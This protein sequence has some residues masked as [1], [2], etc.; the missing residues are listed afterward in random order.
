MQRLIVNVVIVPDTRIK[1]VF[2]TFSF[3]GLK[4]IIIN[5]T[6]TKNRERK[7]KYI[8]RELHIMYCSILIYGRKVNYMH[9]SL[10]H[11]D[12]QEQTTA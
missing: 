1:S 4:K 11:V 10:K 6:K 9:R 7:K 3:S 5:K 2:L 12:I 8:E